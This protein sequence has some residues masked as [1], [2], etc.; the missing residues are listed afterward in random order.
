MV[1]W[2]RRNNSVRPCRDF[3]Q[4]TDACFEGVLSLIGQLTPSARQSVV[5]LSRL[6][7][8]MVGPPLQVHA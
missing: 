8:V 2:L 4:Y 6:L 7:T 1:S 3:G 5:Q